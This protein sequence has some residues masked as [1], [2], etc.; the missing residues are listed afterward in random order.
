MHLLEGRHLSENKSLSNDN[1]EI[2]SKFWNELQTLLKKMLSM[3]LST[4][5]QKTIVNSQQASMKKSGDAA[6][7]RELYKMSLNSMAFSQLHVMH[8]LWTS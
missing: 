3:T 4:T 1:P 5:S 2:C 7:L 8:R 6:K